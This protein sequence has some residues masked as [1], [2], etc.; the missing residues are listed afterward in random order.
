M[1]DMNNKEDQTRARQIK[2][3][4]WKRNNPPQNGPLSRTEHF[5]NVILSFIVTVLDFV[6]PP[7]FCSVT[8]LP[9]YCFF[10]LIMLILLVLVAL[11]LVY[12]FLAQ[13]YWLLFM[14]YSVEDG[15][16]TEL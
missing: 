12:V 1:T 6:L 2:I 5:V 16:G 14:Y 7:I 4:R 15:T 11:V 10:M 3:R 13:V 9:L 8:C